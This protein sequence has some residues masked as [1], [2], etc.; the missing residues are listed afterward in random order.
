MKLLRFNES[1]SYFDAKDIVDNIKEI[2]KDL[3]DEDINFK[4]EPSNDIRVKVLGLYLHDSVEIGPSFYVRIFIQSLWV[5]GE[6]ERDKKEAILNTLRHLENYIHTEQLKFT[7]E[8]YFELY[9]TPK[10]VKSLS[11]G[12]RFVKSF[13]NETIDERIFD[14]SNPAIEIKIIFDK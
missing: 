12:S 9:P 13:E 1:D 7:Y 3:Q 11:T 2:C 8:Y 10:W 5:D 4:I 6:I 14:D